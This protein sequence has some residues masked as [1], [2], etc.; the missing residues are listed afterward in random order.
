MRT[1]TRGA[2][3]QALFRGAPPTPTA[4]YLSAEDIRIVGLEDALDGFREAVARTRLRRL[5]FVV[6]HIHDGTCDVV[7]RDELVAHWRRHG[8]A[9]LVTQLRAQPTEV[10]TVVVFVEG[11]GGFDF[12]AFQIRR[13]SA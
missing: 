1:I 8:L 13:R 3:G 2:V 12:H 6:F 9:P 7:D 5:P 4:A 11:D 10:G